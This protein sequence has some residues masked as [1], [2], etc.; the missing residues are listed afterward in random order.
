M[1]DEQKKKPEGQACV[2][3]KINKTETKNEEKRRKNEE[4]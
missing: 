3:W 2:N 4:K 1:K